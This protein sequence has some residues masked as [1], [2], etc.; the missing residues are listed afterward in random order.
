MPARRA[1]IFV[2]VF[3]SMAGKHAVCRNSQQ[4]SGWRNAEQRRSMR[5]QTPGQRRHC[6]V[7]NA[8]VQRLTPV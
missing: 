3:K 6:E 4:K 5:V 2:I 7:R 1:L 8:D